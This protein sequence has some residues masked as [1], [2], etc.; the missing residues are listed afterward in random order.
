MKEF[1]IGGKR[2]ERHLL[3]HQ[4]TSRPTPSGSMARRT[5]SYAPGSTT[6]QLTKLSE[7]GYLDKPVDPGPTK[8]LPAL[9]SS[10]PIEERA[11][12]YLHANCS[13]CHRKDART[14]ARMDFRFDGPRAGL[15]VCAPAS[16]PGLTG[17]EI[18][19]PGDPAR[20]VLF[21]RISERGENQMPP[22]GTRVVD[23][24]AVSVMEE[25]IRSLKGCE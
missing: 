6:N 2:I 19:A 24:K 7:I 15:E 25:W 9:A 17:G 5:F 12:A 20:S 21:R 16:F 23:V 1:A 14:G 22:L 3:F 8:R 18:V 10:A 13:M 4:T 11:R